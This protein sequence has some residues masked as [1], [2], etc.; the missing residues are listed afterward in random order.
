MTFALMAIKHVAGIELKFFS[1]FE[2]ISSALLVDKE[3]FAG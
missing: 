2:H 3:G 1:D